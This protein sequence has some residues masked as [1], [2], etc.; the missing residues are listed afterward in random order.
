[1]AVKLDSV[2]PFGRS[3]DEYV[4]MFNLS[5]V[6]L[7]QSLLSVADGPASFNA[8]GTQLGYSITSV[9][10]LYAFSALQIKQRFD[11]V[12]DD[13]IDQVANSLDDWVWSYHRSPDQLRESRDRTAQLFCQDFEQGKADGRYHIGSLP[14]LDY[15]DNSY[16]IGLCS[17]FLFLYSEQLSQTF[18]LESICE[19]LRICQEVRIFPLLNLDLQPS[20]HLDFVMSALANLGYECEIQ[21]VAYEFQRNGNRLLRIA[22]PA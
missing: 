9:D 11:A 10:P 4:K 16:R 17:H 19:M 21:P 20:S 22:R 7:Q 1:M 2:V 14:Q 18:H 6:D 12:V 5:D 13:I 3:L 15:P 8:E